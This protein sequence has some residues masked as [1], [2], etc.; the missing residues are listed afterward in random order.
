MRVCVCDCKWR[1]RG[2]VLCRALLFR[3]VV[4]PRAPWKSV[5][6]GALAAG[7]SI[8]LAPFIESVAINLEEKDDGY[9]AV[10]T[11]EK[12]IGVHECTQN[13]SVRVVDFIISGWAES[14]IK[15]CRELLHTAIQ[16][17]PLRYRAL[18]LVGARAC[19]CGSGRIVAYA[20]V[21][22]SELVGQASCHS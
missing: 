13:T 5:L 22:R 14:D 1:L 7:M 8:V 18:P 19:S 11:H 10:R 4:G 12:Q 17:M 6:G 21:R 15:S 20:A 3:V 16:Y 2:V 9:V